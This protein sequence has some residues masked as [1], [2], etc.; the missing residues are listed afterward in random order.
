MEATYYR[1]SEHNYMVIPSPPE[2]DTA[3]YSYRM[4]ELNRIDGLLPCSL[5]HID[6]QRYLYYE[7]TGRQSLTNLFA[8]HK[9]PGPELWVL[10]KALYHIGGSL[11]EYLLDIS[12]L[13]LMPDQIYFEFRTGKFL[14]TYL[15][16]EQ[17][18]PE[19]FRFL[20]DGIDSKDKKAAAAA[21]RMSAAARDGKT[22]MWEELRALVEEEEG[23]SLVAASSEEVRAAA[24]PWRGQ[25]TAASYDRSGN[26][27]RKGT[28]VS[29]TTG[30]GFS[31]SGL[32]GNGV[33]D[34]GFSGNDFSGR[35]FSDSIYKRDT[36]DETAA[37]EDVYPEDKGTKKRKKRHRL[38]GRKKK[39]VNYA[40]NDSYVQNAPN[41]TEAS[42]GLEAK[43][44]KRRTVLCIVLCVLS[45]LCGAGLVAV[46]Y[47]VSMP[48]RERRLCIVG[49]ALWF[50]L[51][52]LL[53]A[54]L[55][56]KRRRR[57][58]AAETEQAEEYLVSGE[59]D[60]PVMQSSSA[61]SA[62]HLMS[63]NGALM[64]TRLSSGD[65]SRK[66]YG[67]GKSTQGTMIDLS[68]LP[69]TIGKEGRYVDV[70]VDDPFVS[71]V[72]ARILRQKDG[73]VAVQ[74]L[75]STN[76]TWVNDII[77]EPHEERPMMQGDILRIG[78][79]EYEFR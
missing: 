15:P 31:G 42:N 63:R 10:L 73:A 58:K 19:V 25:N 18:A 9:I 74:D 67:I 53:C 64:T 71:R 39:A 55:L 47:F 27:N 13:V 34:S 12:Q 77:V 57:K 49:T 28:N 26:Y 24:A 52:I 11:S 33:S 75:G 20:A 6:G 56:I 61:D 22:R 14:F 41:S 45:V 76:G 40:A 66:L 37:E 2:A 44:A 7:I 62:R 30:H 35:D 5:R 46:Q 23:R 36:Y 3:G 59:E 60:Y 72:H 54:D 1:D 32:S 17:Q 51:A 21:Y 8:G 78:R 50:L 43:Q 48:Q 79:A 65:R 16:G 4:L 38:F 69:L 29:G 68:N 70:L